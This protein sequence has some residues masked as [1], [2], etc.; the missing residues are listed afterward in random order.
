M[1]QTLLILEVIS[2]LLAALLLI[3][4]NAKVYKRTL[5]PI[6]QTFG[7]GSSIAIFAHTSQGIRISLTVGGWDSIYG[8]EVAA[9]HYTAIML[10][11]LNTVTALTVLHSFQK[12]RE[13]FFYSILM[14]CHAGLSG[15]VISND[16]FNIY[17]FLELS[18]LASYTLVATKGTQESY[19]AAFE[20]LI[21][22]TISATFYLIGI[23]L[24]YAVTG[25]LNVGIITSMSDII[26][27]SH[28]GRA[29]ATLVVLGI[30]GKCA[31]FPLHFWLVRCYSSTSTTVAAFLSG[32]SSKV[33]LY[34]LAKFVYTIIGARVLVL[35][36]FPLN[37]V[38]LVLSTLAIFVCGLQAIT[39]Q[40]VRQMLSYSSISQIGYISLTLSL[41]SDYSVS[42]AMLQMLA[43]AVTKS[44]LFMLAGGAI[45]QTERRHKQSAMRK[46]YLLVATL[47]LAG[48]PLT[49]GFLGK[50][51]LLLLTVHMHHYLTLLIL[52]IGSIITAIYSWKIFNA[53][54]KFEAGN[55]ILYH[56][57]MSALSL[58][59]I[60]IPLTSG[61]F[62]KL[63]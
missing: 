55:S 58:I 6:A 13:S 23:G 30:I 25:H 36:G 63:I 5:L 2:P 18:S 26:L 8:I 37:I 29:G 4:S 61:F 57:S 43:H 12:D 45:H 50:L 31:L 11:L 35:S 17:V 14:L 41:G 46:I 9:N 34:L 1:Y 38:I 53:L 44:G 56:I 62:L 39:T 21:I 33:G 49:S 48:I 60:A 15:M 27:S 7:V 52:I 32:V 3:F 47:S 51:E 54:H 19:K 42:V 59:N 10:L 40:D 22:G 24:I 20:Y 16:L 28:I